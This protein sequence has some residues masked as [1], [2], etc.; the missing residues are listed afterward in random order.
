MAPIGCG[1]RDP[2][3]GRFKERIH[4]KFEKEQYAFVGSIEAAPTT[5]DAQV[6]AMSIEFGHQ[7]KGGKK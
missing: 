2:D 1:P 7:Y 4:A 6:K 3:V 5:R